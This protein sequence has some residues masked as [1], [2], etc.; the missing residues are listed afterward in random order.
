MEKLQ[1]LVGPE[2]LDSVADA[3]SANCND[4]NATAYRA[5]AAQ[6]AAERRRLRELEEAN[7]DLADRLA[8]IRR[9]A[10]AG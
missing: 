2:F 1:H 3:E 10:Q 4:I 8:D 9:T 5:N 6:W 7:Q